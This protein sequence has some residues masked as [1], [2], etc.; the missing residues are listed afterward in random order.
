MKLHVEM[1][2]LEVIPYGNCINA[3]SLVIHICVRGL[4]AA[5]LNWLLVGIEHGL[6]KNT[7]IRDTVSITVLDIASAFP[8]DIPILV[9][10]FS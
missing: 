10:Q 6:Q 9:D 5:L 1:A 3:M 4:I 8:Y 2:L 7:S